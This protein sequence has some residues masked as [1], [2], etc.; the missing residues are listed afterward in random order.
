MRVALLAR[1]GVSMVSQKPTAVV[2]DDS[3]SSREVMRYALT[4]AAVEVV[5]EGDNGV[6]AIELYDRLRPT[7]LM[8]DIVLPELDGVGAAAAILAK[9]PSAIVIMCSSLAS[10]DKVRACKELGVTHFIVKPFDP[11]R[12]VT[13][14]QMILK[15]MGTPEGVR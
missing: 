1:K 10:R 5:G 8:L 3:K 11:D 13:L 12:V 2:I 4:Q 9:H 7:L 15:R 14:V 6:K